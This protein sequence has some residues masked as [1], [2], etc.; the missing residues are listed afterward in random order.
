MPSKIMGTMRKKKT[1]KGLTIIK[2]IKKIG[3]MS[4]FILLMTIA[5]SMMLIQFKKGL[6][7][8]KNKK[9]KNKKRKIVQFVNL[10][11]SAVSKQFYGF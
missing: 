8:F 9:R 7:P 5:M 10:T 2:G 6:R 3:A 1:K 11:Y 4:E